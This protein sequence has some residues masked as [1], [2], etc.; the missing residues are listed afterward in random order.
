MEKVDKILSERE[1]ISGFY[2]DVARMIQD[3][4]QLWSTGPNWRDGRLTDAQVTSLEMIALKVAR[5]LHGDANH[6]DSW[7]DI[8]GYSEL[9][10]ID[11]ERNNITLQEQLEGFSVKENEQ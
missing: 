4:T 1:K 2:P 7:R 3:T 9:V 11:I 8:A 6:I 5:I 10:A